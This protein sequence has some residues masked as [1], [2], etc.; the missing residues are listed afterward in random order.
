VAVE[1]AVYGEEM[2]YLRERGRI[3]VVPLDPTHPVNTFWDFGLRDK[4]AIWLHQQI[5]MQHRWFRYHED[6]GRSLTWWW[7]YCSRTTARSTASVG[8][9]L[10][11]ARRRRRDPGRA[12]H[13]QAPRPD[14]LG[15][16][17]E[18]VVPRVANLADRHRPHATSWWAT[19]GS[20]ARAAP[21]G[22]KCLDG[23]QFEWNEKLGVW[24]A[25]PLHNW[26]SHG[27]DAW[28][29]FAQGYVATV[30]EENAETTIAAGAA[31]LENR[32]GATMDINRTSST[33]TAAGLH[34][35]RHRLPT[36]QHTYRATSSAS[37][38]SSAAAPP[39]R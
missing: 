14:R 28:R 16:R 26:A 2:T 29:Q 10:P 31:R 7:K 33:P 25:E 8:P 20:T 37:S 1:G 13:H 9:P 27:A 23:Y 6:S 22:I 18:I 34:L 11:A 15:M 36:P 3:G 4:N 21:Q 5:G 39:S 24:S 32:I 30:P 35:R 17:N 38:G 19:T 12:R